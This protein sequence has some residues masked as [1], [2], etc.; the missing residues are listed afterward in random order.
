MGTRLSP[1]TSNLRP[2]DPSVTQNIA[3]NVILSKIAIV[4]IIICF[5]VDEIS[6]NLMIFDIGMLNTSATP[7]KVAFHSGEKC[8]PT[9]KDNL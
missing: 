5:F 1:F 2:I 4:L 9:R 8:P 6:E 7:T 3:S